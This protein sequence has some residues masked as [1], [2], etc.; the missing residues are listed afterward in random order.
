MAQK[1]QLPLGGFAKAFYTSLTDPFKKAWYN[2]QALLLDWPTKLET[3]VLDLK[4]FMLTDEGPSVKLTGEHGPLRRHRDHE[5]LALIH[6]S[7]QSLMPEKKINFHN[8]LKFWVQ[9]LAACADDLDTWTLVAAAD[10]VLKMKPLSQKEAEN[11]L[12]TLCYGVY[13]GTLSPLPVAC[14][15][16]FAW[17]SALDKGLEKN[18]AMEKARDCYESDDW[19]DGEVAYDP[20]LARFFPTFEELRQADSDMGFEYWA[21]TLYGPLYDHLKNSSSATEAQL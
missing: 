14:K 17:L 13:Q 8:L 7:A 5:G 9:H 10:G 21:E 15:T 4:A 1:G 3:H 19:K 16:A 11:H 12:Q 2:Y 18:K 6:L 20:Y